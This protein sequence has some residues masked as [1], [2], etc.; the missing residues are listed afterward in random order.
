VVAAFGS[1]LPSQKA[2]STSAIAQ[3]LDIVASCIESSVPTR[4]YAVSLGG[5]V[6]HSAEKGTR[7]A[8]LGRLSDAISAFQ[9]RIAAGA[10][11]ADVVLPAYS[12]FGRPVAAD[13]NE[14]TDHATAGPIF[15]VWNAVRGG[16]I[17]EQPSLA[18]LDQGDLKF[19]TDFGSVCATFP[20]DVR[21]ADPVQSLG[22]EFSLAPLRRVS[23]PA[24]AGV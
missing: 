9:Q 5:F 8:L 17:G 12:E 20:A 14:G 23:V 24:P 22:A 6:T 21:V 16:F 19:G 18:D 1:V 13:A 3:Q 4:V 2:S 15:D 11:A 7:S 10:R